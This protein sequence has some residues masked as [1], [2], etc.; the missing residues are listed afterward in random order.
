M[1]TITLNTAAGI[2]L[3][4]SIFSLGL[5]LKRTPKS[6][7]TSST[8]MLSVSDIVS[9][10]FTAFI[11]FFRQFY[12][13]DWRILND[14][15]NK[16]AHHST[17]TY[18][19]TSKVGI[20]FSG[21]S[22]NDKEHDFNENCDFKSVFFQYAVFFI[23]FIQA[24]LS[25]MSFSMDFFVKAMQINRHLCEWTQMKEKKFTTVHSKNIVLASESDST[26]QKN[27][28][29]LTNKVKKRQLLDF[30]SRKRTTFA[31]LSQWIIP[32]I[33][34]G[35]FQFG[36]YKLTNVKNR[37]ED[38]TC[39]F[40]ANYLFE[41]C[42]DDFQF[43]NE[44]F[45]VNVTGSI[46]TFHHYIKSEDTLL[47][48]NT[49]SPE[50]QKT[51][52]KIYDI[53]QKTSKNSKANYDEEPIANLYDIRQLFQRATQQYMD[54]KTITN[55][56]FINENTTK[57]MSQFLRLLENPYNCSS[58]INNISI[59]HLT[60]D[61]RD[62]FMQLLNSTL[63]NNNENSISNDNHIFQCMKSR[64]VISTTF[65]KIHLFIVLILMYFTPVLISTLLLIISHYECR[66]M[67]ETLKF[68]ELKNSSINNGI[69]ILNDVA[70]ELPNLEI[71][72][73]IGWFLRNTDE[74]SNHAELTGIQK[75]DQSQK[76]DK[77]LRFENIAFELSC[78]IEKL[79]NFFEVF[80]VNVFV[81]IILWTPF[82]LQ[83]I[84]KVF[85]CCSIPN[86]LMET[87]FLATIVFTVFRNAVNLNVMKI[88][89]D[90]QDLR[91][92]NSIHII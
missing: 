5:L 13:R 10:I 72:P 61:M 55:N 49:D 21:N 53:V 12:T 60:L 44:T 66:S 45:I 85:F 11:L 37:P 27:E 25:L 77:Y 65:L 51:I 35:I 48:T 57:L 18:E 24:F 64:C 8:S 68:K 52:L 30:S 16:A 6:L 40:M 26:Q 67:V 50:M 7:L 14:L 2:L 36:D 80:K 32:A 76:N 87:T 42:N 91:K 47:W 31:I 3:L 46:P 20:Y 39:A 75:E 83:I 38:A 43:S 71:A 89:A 22:K 86:W 73:T 1:H 34:S 54:D 23:P 90:A 74:E 88:E 70:E 17:H 82:F 79:E 29:K 62:K 69:E 63:V 59:P 78:E 56:N 58:S 41:K 84:I 92:S 19:T 4:T 81:A 15:I 9:S 28:I 33:F